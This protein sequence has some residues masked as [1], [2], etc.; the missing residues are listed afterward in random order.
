[1]RKADERD[2]YSVLLDAGYLSPEELSVLHINIT[3]R[4]SLPI[5]ILEER[6]ITIRQG[7]DLKNNEIVCLSES[8]SET[9]CILK[10][11][12]L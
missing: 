4:C 8:D 3:N 6:N 5:K 10:V 1:M 7:K 9:S 11:K 2:K 12:H